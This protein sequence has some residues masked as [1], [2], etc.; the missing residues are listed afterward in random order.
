MENLIFV[1]CFK[2]PLINFMEA[3]KGINTI[4]SHHY[5]KLVRSAPY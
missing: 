5:N 1:M 2:I 4:K 3:S